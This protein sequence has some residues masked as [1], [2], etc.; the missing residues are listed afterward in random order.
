MIQSSG[1]TSIFVLVHDM[2][3]TYLL[4]MCTY[5]T[6]VVYFLFCKLMLNGM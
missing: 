5:L 2:Y 6:Y 1:Y 3:V 4:C